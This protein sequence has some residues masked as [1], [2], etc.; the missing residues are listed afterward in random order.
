MLT[1]SRRVALAGVEIETPLLVPAISSKAVGPVFVGPKRKGE[2]VPA[3]VIHTETLLY[4]MDDSLLI[5]AYDIHHGL[6]ASVDS[7]RD[8]FGASIYAVPNLLIIDSGWYEKSL[9]TSSGPWTHEVGSTK[10]FEELDYEDVLR[11][12]DPSLHALIT[13][14][15]SQGTYDEQIA[16][17]RQFAADHPVHATD[18][19]LK[20]QNTRTYHDFKQVAISTV[21]QLKAVGV[22]GVAEKDLGDTLVKRLAAI[23]H[24]RWALDDAGVDA[25]IHVFGGLDPLTTPLYFACGAEIFDGLSWLRYAYRDGLCLHRESIALLDGRY[26]QRFAI[27]TTHAQLN[28]IE[29]IMELGRA[30][31]VFHHFDGDWEKLR[32]GDVLRP[33]YEAV[34]SALGNKHGR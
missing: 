17:A 5:S 22:V 12:L 3:S 29:A 15:D 9:E 32:H 26:D 33:A 11:S 4:A 25:P 19:L 16:R 10:P 7:F 21:A 30:L 27:V 2:L 18:V 31:K 28:N 20:P 1:R 14:W 13:T 24:L 8:N 34:A 23:T 6:L